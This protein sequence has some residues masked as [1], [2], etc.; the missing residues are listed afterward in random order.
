M[1]VGVGRHAPGHLV[2]GLAELQQHDLE[3]RTVEP[4]DQALEGLHHAVVVEEARHEHHPDPVALG[5]RREFQVRMP[6]L[7]EAPD[8]RRVA[9]VLG[10]E[11]VAEGVQGGIGAGDQRGFD[12]GLDLRV[13]GVQRFEPAQRAPARA[14]GLELVLVGENGLM[15]PP[16]ED[17]A[18]Y[19]VARIARQRLLEG[20]MRGASAAGAPQHQREALVRAGGIRGDLD[21]APQRA[22]GH[23][24][25]MGRQAQAGIAAQH[26]R[27]TVVELD[28]VAPGGGIEVALA[29]LLGAERDAQQ[30]PDVA[31]RQARGLAVLGQRAAKVALAAALAAG[32]RRGRSM[33][34]G[35]GGMPGF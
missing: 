32:L 2:A 22:L 35:D 6:R 20:R 7:R 15:R 23:R 5:A 28:R 29:E 19:E 16:A 26:F 13:A 27:M 3:A 8:Q 12:L 25:V 11:V 21:Q 4:A 14:E 17:P 34:A 9:P 10:I 1:R 30:D 18:R 33:A 31:R 24:Q